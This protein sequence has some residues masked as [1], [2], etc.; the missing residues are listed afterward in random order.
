VIGYSWVVDIRHLEVIWHEQF[1]NK[2]R[3]M[4]R[5]A[6]KRSVTVKVADEDDFEEWIPI[7]IETQKR[8]GQLVTG[9]EG[10]SA[11]YMFKHC[12]HFATLLVA[13]K[14]GHVISGFWLFKIQRHRF[15]QLSRLITRSF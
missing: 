2:Q 15:L 8:I 11:R 9:K 4:I 12:K 3:N 14:D 1:D 10:D 6:I 5:K 13:K 7:K